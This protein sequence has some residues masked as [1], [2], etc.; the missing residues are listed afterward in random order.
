[1]PKRGFVDLTK[2]SDPPEFSDN[3]IEA[4]GEPERN[5]RPFAESGKRLDTT[6]AGRSRQVATN[7]QCLRDWV[8]SL[9]LQQVNLWKWKR[10]RYLRTS[11]SGTGS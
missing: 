6:K 8:R 2:D 1:M 9:L 10:M 5:L 4:P 11:R 7:L 3:E